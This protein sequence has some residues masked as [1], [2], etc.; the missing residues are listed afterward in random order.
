MRWT[1]WRWSYTTSASYYDIE[2]NEDD[3][4]NG[5]NETQLAMRTVRKVLDEKKKET[6]GTFCFVSQWLHRGLRDSYKKLI[7]TLFD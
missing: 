4:D 3:G 1:E 5:G 2:I 6:K 7:P